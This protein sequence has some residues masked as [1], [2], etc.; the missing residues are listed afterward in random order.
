MHLNMALELWGIQYH[1]GWKFGKFE[2]YSFVAK[3]VHKYS[4]G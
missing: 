4:Y 1:S 3:M 2:G